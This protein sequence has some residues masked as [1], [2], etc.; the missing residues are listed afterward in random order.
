[1]VAVSVGK[2]KSTTWKTR[3]EKG[4]NRVNGFKNP[5]EVTNCKKAVMEASFSSI[6]TQ[7]KTAKSSVHLTV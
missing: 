2:A 6:A 7:D 1:M 5:V 4:K 3:R